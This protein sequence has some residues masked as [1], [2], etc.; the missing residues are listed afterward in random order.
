MGVP[1]LLIALGGMCRQE[2]L[3]GYWWS[4]SIE[5]SF[6]RDSFS[7][8]IRLISVWANFAADS[9]IVLSRFST[10]RLISLIRAI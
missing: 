8:N 5:P 10:S 1:I 6:G 2:R 7:S 9:L 3:A 4:V